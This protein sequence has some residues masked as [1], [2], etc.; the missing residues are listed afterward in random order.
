MW[1]SGDSRWVW[2]ERSA[3][4]PWVLFRIDTDSNPGQVVKKL[5]NPLDRLQSYLALCVSINKDGWK[6]S[7]Y[8]QWLIKI[9][10]QQINKY[11]NTG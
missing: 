6:Q 7:I 3:Y 5:H 8:E 1:S 11:K 4:C 10:T 2:N 9:Q